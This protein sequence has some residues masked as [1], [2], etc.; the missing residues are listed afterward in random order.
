MK[1]RQG[2]ILGMSAVLIIAAP[3]FLPEEFGKYSA[4]FAGLAL[5]AYLVVKAKR[6]SGQ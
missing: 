5:G 3:F 6:K 2:L 4:V 1:L